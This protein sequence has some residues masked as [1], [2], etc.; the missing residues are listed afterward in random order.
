MLQ[1]KFHV[2]I[3]ASSH[4]IRRNLCQDMLSHVL[5]FKIFEENY[6]SVFFSSVALSARDHNHPKFQCPDSI[7]QIPSFFEPFHH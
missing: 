5:N 2:S 7:M 3:D 4:E 6:C 1:G